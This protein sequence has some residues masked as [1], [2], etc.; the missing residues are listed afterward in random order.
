[1]VGLIGPGLIG[2]ALLEQLRRQAE[3]LRR[4]F[5]IDLRLRAITTS[6]RM[7]LGDPALDLGAWRAALDERGQAADLD[8]FT[9]HVQAAHLPHAVVIDCTAADLGERYEAWLARGIHV[10]TPNKK[11]GAGPLA[12][13]RRLRQSA[14]GRRGHYFYEAT[15][16]AGLPVIKTLRD[17]VQTGD[18]VLAV[19]GVLSGTLSY[20][21]NALTPDTP[22]SSLVLE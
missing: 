5:H 20:L 15:V 12:R 14:R 4:E 10:L 3:V 7:V 2:R 17:L 11:P 16:G 6:S 9:E 21:F 8:A 22:F 1:S 19:E 13:Y 18:R